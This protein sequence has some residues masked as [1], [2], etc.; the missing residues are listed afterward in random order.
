MDGEEAALGGPLPRALVQRL[1]LAE[2][3]MVTDA[4]LQDDLWGEEQPASAATTLQAHVARLRRALEPGASAREATVLVRRGP[5]YA[6][7]AASTDAADFERLASRG[8]TLLGVDP[9]A[10]AQ[11]LQE[12]LA[13]WRGPA[14]VEVAGRGWAAPEVRRLE[15]LLAA[16]REDRVAADLERG[17]AAAASA[18]ASALVAAEPLRERGWELLALALHR[19]GRRGDALAAL[20]QLAERLADELGA[21][22]GPSVSALRAAVEAGDASLLGADRGAAHGP[23]HPA[24]RR[25]IARTSNVPA[26]TS[27]I[28]GRE[29]E[30]A[31]VTDLLAQHRLVTLTGTGGAGKTRLALEVARRQQDDDGPWLV[32]LAPLA[33]G[34]LLPEVVA[35]ALGLVPPGGPSPAAALAS[36]LRPRRLLLVLDNCEHVV[37]EAA[38]FA[39]VLLASCPDVRVLATSREPLLVDGERTHEVPVLSGGPDGEAVALFVDRARAASPAWHPTRDDLERVAEVCAA[40]DGLPLAVELAA[41]QVRVLALADVAALADD[42]SSL[43][44]LLRGGRRTTSRHATMQAAVSWSYDRL[45][46]AEREVF[47]DLS[48]FS[49]G[50][51]LDAAQRVLQRP[52][53]VPV[54]AD[55]VGRSLVVAS[56][57]GPQRRFHLLEP[58]RQH[59]AERLDPGRREVLA[60]RRVQWVADLAAHADPSMRGRLAALETDRLHDEAGNIRAA[61]SDGDPAVVLTIASGFFWF[62]YREGLVAEGLG[63]LLPALEAVAGDPD[64]EPDAATRARAWSGAALL[65]YLAGDL[66]GVGRALVQVGEHAAR[67]DDPLVQAQSLALVAYF[68][69][70]GGQVAAGRGHAEA[71][72]AISDALG[73]A[74]TRAES[75]MVLGE[76]ERQDGHADEALARL[77]AAVAEADACGYSWVGL[78]SRW[79]QAKVE[80]ARGRLA[81]AWAALLDSLERAWRVGETT[82]WLVGLATASHLLHRDGR[83]QEAAQVAG[84]VA[85]QAGRIGYSP[86]A[87]DADLDR[88]AAELAAG[89]PPDAYAAAAATGRDLS[90]S[91]VMDLVRALGAQHRSGA[92]AVGEEAVGEHAVGEHG[93]DL[94]DDDAVASSPGRA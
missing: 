38:A 18:A 6:L 37:E 35:T 25:P 84:A 3:G 43:G 19:Q 17:D 29:A 31:Q 4:A 21:D 44:T 12:A 67:C 82:S 7:H 88:Y 39:E 46:P 92:Q 89:V 54:V 72:L 73:H 23:D 10:A 53:V 34:R 65:S 49:G 47:C 63:H 70:G 58:L 22:P 45:T 85:W 8:R 52:D 9:E 32:E 62:W 79:S 11:A 36:V 55:L 87:M 66:P 80:V 42:G 93:V 15:H 69:A 2:G 76:V 50:F 14:L 51:T 74:A 16:A 56:R 5:G 64:G 27:P 48:V 91:E 1:A 26:P 86:A 28:V 75:L 60:A 83:A 41:A 30:V 78:S 13:L 77:E 61:L 40:L 68:E 20:D 57:P 24:G 94:R 81:E 71:A 33:D 59:A 90:A